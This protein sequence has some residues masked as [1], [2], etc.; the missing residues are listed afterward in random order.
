MSIQNAYEILSGVGTL[1]V[2]D[3]ET[4]KPSMDSAPGVAWTEISETD[5]G[6]KVI[7]SQEI[8]KLFSDQHTGAIKAIRPE[9]GLRV[10]TNII[11]STLELLAKVLGGQ[12]VTDTA[13]GASTVGYRTIGFH[14]GQ[15]VT[16]FAMLFRGTFSAYGSSYNAQF[17]LPRGYFDGEVGMEFKKDDKVLVPVQFEALMDLDESTSEYKFGQFDMQDAAETG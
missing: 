17:Y 14:R 13:A 7:A 2:A 3:G 5:G 6:V 16:E 12:T 4:A 10:E 9:E 15:S 1:Y 11:R 8:T